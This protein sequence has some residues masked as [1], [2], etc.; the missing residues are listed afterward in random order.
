MA[1]LAGLAR[2]VTAIVSNL[3]PDNKESDNNLSSSKFTQKRDK[4][5]PLPT[6][7]E[8][9]EQFKRNFNIEEILRNPAIS[10]KIR[11]NSLFKLGIESISHILERDALRRNMGD[12]FFL[13]E[14]AIQG[15]R[16]YRLERRLE[17][18]GM[19]FNEL[20]ASNFQFSIEE[21]SL[22]HQLSLNTL[23]NSL[24]IGPQIA[25]KV[26]KICSAV[27]S[28]LPT[29]R[30]RTS[31]QELIQIL[32]EN[33]LL[34]YAGSPFGNLLSTAMLKNL[35][36]D[37]YCYRGVKGAVNSVFKQEG[38][39]SGGSAVDSVR[40]LTYGK[41]SKYFIPVEI[42]PNDLSIVPKG[43]IACYQRPG[44]FFN[45][46]SNRRSYDGHIQIKTSKGWASTN[47]QLME[48]WDI[49]YKEIRNREDYKIYAFIPA[50]Y[51]KLALKGACLASE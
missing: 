36:S 6:P 27:I 17:R 10:E 34:A 28:A 3:L 46:A 15:T 14:S 41:L 43:T 11:S 38:G 16:A 47:E 48:G 19:R 22:K 33:P 18:I 45:P 4:L 30:F 51:L 25:Q 40:Q 35:S 13:K 37:G 8:I 44:D 21:I 23:Q 26:P 5:L 9:T 7:E 24:W 31:G 20:G 1:S 42:S 32:R 49:A 2:S 12:E 29:P 50:D 39:L